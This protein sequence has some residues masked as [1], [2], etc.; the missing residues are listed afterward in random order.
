MGRVDTRAYK[1][2][3]W[4]NALVSPH[5]PAIKRVTMKTALSVIAYKN[6]KYFFLG[7]SAKVGPGR[8]G[9]RREPAH[10]ETEAHTHGKGSPHMREQKPTH[11][12]NE[13]C[14]CKNKSPHTWEMKPAHAVKAAYLEFESWTTR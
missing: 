5:C 1:R 8:L 3:K 6:F 4:V 13:A 10:A 11:M 14:T 2:S 9:H 7:S 12:G